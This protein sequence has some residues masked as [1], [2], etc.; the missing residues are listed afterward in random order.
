MTK[1]KKIEV[2]LSESSIELIDSDTKIDNIIESENIIS[3][4]IQEQQPINVSIG[5][6]QEINV[7]INSGARGIQ[8]KSA[9]EI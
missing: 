4:S 7:S 6:E 5:K 3:A 9:Y 1:D 2:F 8:G